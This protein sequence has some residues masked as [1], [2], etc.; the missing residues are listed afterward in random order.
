MKFEFLRCKSGRIRKR[1]RGRERGW[2]NGRMER[3]G[4]WEKENGGIGGRH[5]KEAKRHA[6][7]MAERHHVK[8]AKQVQWHTRKHEWW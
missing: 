7:K 8:K 3:E 5:R 6:D 2:E 4:E 1:E